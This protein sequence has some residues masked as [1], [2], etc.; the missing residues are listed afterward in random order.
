M[1]NI[2]SYKFLGTCVSIVL[3]GLFGYSLADSDLVGEVLEGNNSNGISTEQSSAAVMEEQRLAVEQEDKYEYII[4]E[5]Q[6]KIAIFLQNSN[7]PEIVFDVYLHHLPDM[8]KQR[9]LEGVG[10]KDYETL[11]VAIE[12]L[13]S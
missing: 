2:F 13:I 3:V 8:D 9:L 4:K 10:I 6:G 11:L 7:K 12:D 5:Y 1:S